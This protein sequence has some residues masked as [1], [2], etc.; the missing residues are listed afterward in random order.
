MIFRQLFDAQSS[1]YT[2]LLGCADA[3]D[4]VL[5]DPVFEQHER[6]LALIRELGLKVRYVLDT[7]VHADH[8]TAAWLMQ[9]K[10][11]AEIVL[12]ARAQASGVDIEVDHGDVLAFGNCS[13]SVR[14]TPG[15]TA[16][17]VSYVSNSNSL[18]FT[19]DCL[20]IRGAGRTD[21]QGG[22]VD[23]MYRSI[24]E[25]IFTLPD[26]CLVYPAHDYAGRTVST[27]AEEKR[28]NPRIGGDARLEDF[29][30]FMDNLGLPHP[31]LLDIA[32]P[33]NLKS[34]RPEN[35]KL[36][37]EPDWGPITTTF[38]GVPEIRPD[39]VA[40]H[41]SELC[42]LDVRAP[43]EFSGQLGHIGGAELIP[44]NELRERIDEVCQERPIVTICQ[45]G[46]RSAMAVKILQGAG[47][48][49]VAN[50]PGGMLLWHR[51]AFP[52]EGASD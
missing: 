1:T 15:H 23:Q 43:E 7:H 51:L 38:A 26:D 8:V 22:S 45:S 36:P 52:V 20:L 27:I 37:A 40:R 12:S 2:Y 42:L 41:A 34:G 6:D 50:L 24:R 19:G 14:A 35:N 18:A 30:G 47:R 3:G 49:E 44:L 48:K 4:A 31:R 17:C 25:Q 5:I 16:G 39:W 29:A 28:F 33:A 11:G 46:K 21:F 9:K 13:L 32:V 10:T